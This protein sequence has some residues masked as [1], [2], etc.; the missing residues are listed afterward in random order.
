MVLLLPVQKTVVVREFNIDACAKTLCNATPCKCASIAYCF[1]LEVADESV[2]PIL[3]LAFVSIR[4][5]RGH[6]TDHSGCEHQ[7]RLGIELSSSITLVSNM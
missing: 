2:Y 7:S 1:F 5:Y 3:L 4:R 6:G